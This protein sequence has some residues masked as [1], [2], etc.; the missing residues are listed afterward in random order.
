MV[1]LSTRVQCTRDAVEV[2]ASG[3]RNRQSCQDR[4][5]YTGRLGAHERQSG[6]DSDVSEFEGKV[7]AITG[8]AAGIG[9]SLAVE[10]AKRGA[11]LATCDVNEAGLQETSV[12]CEQVGARIEAATVNVA[13]RDAVHAWADAIAEHFGPVHYV[14]NNA[15]VA[16]TG[17][18]ERCT[19]ADIERVMDIDFWGVVNGSKAFLPY[20]LDTGDGHIVNMSSVMGLF[21]APTQSAYASAKFAVRGFTEA[22]RQELLLAGHPIKVTCVHPGGIKTD[23]AKNGA[24]VDPESGKDFATFFDRTAMV[25]PDKAALII[26]N[27]V[28]K[29][30]ARVLVGADAHAI[31]FFIRLTGANYQ[32]LLVAAS[33]QFLPASLREGRTN[34]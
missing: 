18:I 33:R 9:R 26:L 24:S 11:K 30:R 2:K 29:G 21:A 3:R 1:L 32:R 12:L 7:V 23:I 6:S 16:F 5:V 31:D 14:F 22:L 28:A 4:S 25:G 17:S 19:F 27:G 34:T 13:D 10:L 20:L 8:A 15:G